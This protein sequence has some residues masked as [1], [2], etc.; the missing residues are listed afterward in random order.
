[1]NKINLIPRKISTGLKQSMQ[2]FQEKTW[3]MLQT[4]LQFKKV[5]L[6]LLSLPKNPIA[7]TAY[8]TEQRN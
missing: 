6:L 2:Y 8:S 5:Y 1:M 3:P 7:D 4:C